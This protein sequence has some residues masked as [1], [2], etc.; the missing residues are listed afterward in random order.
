MQKGQ[1]IEAS[2]SVYIRFYR[3][4]KRVAEKLCELDDKHYSLKAK[5]VRL[6]REK[7]MLAVNTKSPSNDARAVTVSEFWDS[8]FLPHIEQPPPNG[9]KPSS[10]HSYKAIWRQVLKDHLEDRT[11]VE[12]EPADASDF[13]TLLARRLGRRALAHVRSL[14]SSIFAH[15]VAERIIKTNPWREAK[16]RGKVRAPKP[17]VYYS[18][19]QANSFEEKLKDDPRSLAMFSLGWYEALRPGEI[20]GLRWEDIGPDSVHIRRSAWRGKVT[21]P[22]TEEAASSVPLVSKC[23]DALEAW[24][25]V[26][27]GPTEG[28]VFQNRQGRPINMQN[29]SRREMRPKLGPGWK[30]WYGARRGAATNLMNLTGLPQASAELLRHKTYGVTVA[31]YIQQD[32]TALNG[33][34][35]KLEE[36]LAKN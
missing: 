6:L 32:R 17:A 25:R 7:F 18:E 30:G 36:K 20:A 16:V 31:A 34:I 11:F 33:A 9:L 4:G 5:S 26:C 29:Y 3:D 27:G 1:L 10:I 15:A 14:G 13:L 19:D 23:K 21:D 2:G 35:A 28:F 24:R 22:K 12:Y 8:V